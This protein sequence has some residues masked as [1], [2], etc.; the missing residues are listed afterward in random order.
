VSS[1]SITSQ[2]LQPSEFVIFVVT[3]YREFVCYSEFPWQIIS[4][5]PVILPEQ[6]EFCGAC[7]GSSFVPQRHHGIDMHGPQRGNKAGDKC[8]RGNNEHNDHEG[9][10]IVGADSK[11]KAADETAR[12]D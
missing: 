1:L 12:K 5:L 10:W 11:Q 9:E 8:H 7:G 3:G 4:G 6:A 2:T